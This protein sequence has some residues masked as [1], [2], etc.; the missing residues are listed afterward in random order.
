MVEDT[1]HLHLH[2]LSAI[3]SEEAIDH[4]LSTLW[5]TRKTGLSS[6]EKSHFQSL[7]NL[8]SLSQ[9]DPVL[10]C[11][12][13]LIRKCAYQNFTGDDLLKLFPP[14]LPLDLQSILVL[15][16]QKNKDEWKEDVSGEQHLLPRTSVSCQVRTNVSPSLTSFP[17]SEMPTFQWPRQGDPLTRLSHNDF[18]I[19]MPLVADINGSGLSACF[20]PDIAS[21]DNL[22]NLPRLKSMTWTMENHGTSPGDKVAIISLKLHDHSKSS[23]GE[24]DVRFKLSRDILDAMLRS[25]TY[26][27]EQLST[28]GGTSSRSANKKQKR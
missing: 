16:F 10:A 1:L 17:S 19:P 27:S 3:K 24:T 7:L 13:S 20:Q 28:V 12:R 11:L 6:S 25:L 14:D 23:P 15:S 18:G 2:K 9:L 26:I 8:P 22:E 5:K 21:S 4:I